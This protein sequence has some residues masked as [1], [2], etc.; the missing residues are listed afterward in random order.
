MGEACT[1]RRTM[2]HL[3]CESRVRAFVASSI[4]FDHSCSAIAAAFG[5]IAGSMLLFASN[6]LF[7]M[8][9]DPPI[10]SFFCAAVALG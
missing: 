4:D 10:T 6:A 3:C 8:Q 9:A 5:Q 1:P 2:R 7:H